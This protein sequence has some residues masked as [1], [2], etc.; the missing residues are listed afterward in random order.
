MQSKVIKQAKRVQADAVVQLGDFGFI[1]RIDRDDVE[2]TLT[3]LNRWF[4][5]SDIPL[6]WLDGN[7]ENFE[8]MAEM[9]AATDATEMVQ[10]R[11]HITYLPRGLRWEWGGL[12]FM[13]LGGAH[14]IDVDDRVPYVSWWPEERI[15]HADVHRALDNGEAGVDVMLTH[16]SPHHPALDKFLRSFRLP[17]KMEEQSMASRHALDGVVDELKP[18]LL[19]HGHYHHRLTGVH[20]ETTILGLNHSKTGAQ[21]WAVLDTDKLDEQIEELRA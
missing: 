12:G 14:S 10:L 18:K 8:M 9:G 1:F 5:D 3:N 21:A 16:D 19:V 11:S 4:A 13:A 15:T 20:G 6:Y 17:Y 7:H 2:R